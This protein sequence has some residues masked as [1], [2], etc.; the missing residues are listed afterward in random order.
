[1]KLLILKNPLGLEENGKLT[2]NR[3][4]LFPQTKSWKAAY[5]T[6]GKF[7]RLTFGAVLFRT[8]IKTMRYLQIFATRSL[9]EMNA[10]VMYQST[11]VC[12]S[13]AQRHIHRPVESRKVSK[14]V[15]NHKIRGRVI[16]YILHF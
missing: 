5:I 4:T 10:N 1:M 3:I 9:N 2:T 6:E 16:K 15:N 13:H 12:F 8:W 7:P 11:L 14:I